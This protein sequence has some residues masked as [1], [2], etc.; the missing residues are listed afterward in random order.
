M[1]VKTGEHR[2]AHFDLGV[3]VTGQGVEYTSLLEEKGTG[4]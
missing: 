1:E 3:S 2:K 4:F